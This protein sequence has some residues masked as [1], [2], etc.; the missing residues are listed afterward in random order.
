MEKNILLSA[1]GT[2]VLTALIAYYYFRHESKQ[3]YNKIYN[4]L[5]L[6]DGLYHEL[7]LPTKIHINLKHKILIQRFNIERKRL[8]LALSIYAVSGNRVA[9]L[10]VGQHYRRLAAIKCKLKSANLNSELEVIDIS[11]FK[12]L[13]DTECPKLNEYYNAPYFKI[14]NILK[15]LDKQL[16][17][18]R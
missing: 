5:D 12:E 1:L 11:K 18:N 4:K 8:N 2:I 7:S 17:H 9:E 15:D 10:K 6:E 13:R 14:V 16:T 3:M